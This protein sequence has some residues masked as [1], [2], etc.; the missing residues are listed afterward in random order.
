MSDPQLSPE[1]MAHIERAAR[2]ATEATTPEEDPA[3]PPLH[4]SIERLTDDLIAD[5]ATPDVAPATSTKRKRRSK[6]ELAQDPDFKPRK[7]K[8]TQEE[9]PAPG[10][11]IDADTTTAPD[12]MTIMQDIA[13]TEQVTATL[14]L[15]DTQEELDSFPT[16]QDLWT[17]I[18]HCKWLSEMV[19]SDVDGLLQE[20]VA[21]R[22]D[23]ARVLA[24]VNGIH[25]GT[26]S[27]LMR[28]PPQTIESSPPLKQAESFALLAKDAKR[29]AVHWLKSRPRFFG[30]VGIIADHIRMGA[31]GD[32]SAAGKL[33]LSCSPPASRPF[34]RQ[35]LQ[36]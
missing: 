27:L 19:R 2:L 7:R 29:L 16:T 8:P 34:I 22:Q 18:D 10:F 11:I 6:A 15:A 28:V 21:L 35:L 24:G 31:Y 13:V 3:P 20:V 25:Q 1:E 30:D 5:A 12:S 14:S 17:A 32:P 9:D 33:L 4:S 23:V 36:P 26:T